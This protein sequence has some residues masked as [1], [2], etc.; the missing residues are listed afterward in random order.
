MGGWVVLRNGWM[1]GFVDIS[2]MFRNDV[3][4][5]GAYEAHEIK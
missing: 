4:Q 3:C 2:D 5:G 1:R